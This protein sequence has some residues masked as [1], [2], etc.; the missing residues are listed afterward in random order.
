MDSSL[1][2][3]DVQP[4]YVRVTLKGKVLQLVLSENVK[5]DL[6]TAQRS[7]TT[8]ELVVKMPKV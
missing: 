6:S 5:C 7:Q 8:G 3:V 1:V 2:D 4:N